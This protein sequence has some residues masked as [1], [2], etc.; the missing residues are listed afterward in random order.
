[1]SDSTPPSAQAPSA[2]HGPVGV[3]KHLRRAAEDRR[4][5]DDADD[6]ADGVPQAERR[7][8][9]RTRSPRC[10]LVASVG[11]ESSWPAST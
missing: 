10:A 1:M 4:A 8:G 3:L 7:R 11:E 2:C 9:S 5:D 6:Q